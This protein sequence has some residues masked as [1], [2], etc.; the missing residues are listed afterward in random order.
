MDEPLWIVT[1][2]A[3]FLGNV[4]VR[5]LLAAGARVRACVHGDHV[6]LALQGLECEQVSMDVTDP[7]SVVAAFTA[8]GPVRV[9][10]CAGIVSIAGTV[11]EAVRQVN[12]GGTRAVLDACRAV[13]AQRLVYVSSVH[14][15]A[16]PDPPAVI[17]E[18]DRAADFDPDRV[19]GEYAKTKAEATREVLAATD[20]SR[21]VVHPSGLIGPWDFGETHLT[22]LIRDASTGRLPIAVP[23]G[24][25]FVDVRDVAS[26]IVAAASHGADG[27]TYLLTGHFADIADVAGTA[28]ELSG[29]RRPRVMPM[30]LAKAIA[31]AA[32][33]WYR[34]R[35]TK[36]LFT[37][38]SLHT[39][40]APA[41]FS[42]ERATRELGYAPRPLD[43]TLRDT[44]AWLAGHPGR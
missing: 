28:A 16:E 18:L 24:Y 35:R 39:L 15:I 5:Q 22:R 14:A 12:V 38:Y 25:D 10:H 43:N 29:R 7:A 2:A 13:A 6:P 34:M 26:G 23:G 36:P 9:V 21:V 11:S 4:L 37:A 17:R 40:G 31:P 44:V 30:W 3:G 1:G 27:R 32:E 19:V 20:V 33:L 41:Q 42:H 8:D